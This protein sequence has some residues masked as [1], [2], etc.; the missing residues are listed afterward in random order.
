MKRRVDF[1]FLAVAV[2]LLCAAGAAIPA[3]AQTPPQDDLTHGVV[4]ISLMDGEVSVR[5]GDSG[6]WVAGVINAPLMTDD[7]I[8]TGQTSRAEVQFDAA[9]VLR[10]G[11]NAEVHLARVENGRYYLEVAR[12]MVTF[13]MLRQSNA[14]IEV[15]TPSVSVRPARV[16]A[17]RVSVTETGES[18]IT[19]RSGR[20]GD[21]YAERHAMG[22]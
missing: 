1:R 6:E 12:G 13:R 5:R 2:A 4:R 20:R 8:S 18:E 22:L 15:N 17:F 21:L 11:A 14:D 9:N 3:R 19:A 7:R 10:I 16:G